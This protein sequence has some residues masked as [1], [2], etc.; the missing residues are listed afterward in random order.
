MFTREFKTKKKKLKEKRESFYQKNYYDEIKK[1]R[2]MKIIKEEFPI[3]PMDRILPSPKKVHNRPGLAPF[4][5]DPK[6]MTA[7]LDSIYS[8]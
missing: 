5:F 8:S 1:N 3:E 4:E 7:D 6:E 2:K